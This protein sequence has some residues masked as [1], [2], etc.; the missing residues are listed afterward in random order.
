LLTQ[1]AAKNRD[2][3]GAPNWRGQASIDSLLRI[4]AAIAG[5]AFLATTAQAQFF[6]GTARVDVTP[7]PGLVMGGYGARKAPAAK[8]H[9]PLY[10]TALV[11]ESPD[12]SVAILT[13]DHRY[14]FSARAEEEI[15]RRFGIQHVLISSSHTH[16]GPVDVTT[17]IEDGL[18][19]A[20]GDAHA[21]RFPAKLAAG[22][23]SVYLGHNRRLIKADGKVEMFWRNAERKPT[24]P[25]D[26]EV[27][28][29]RIDDADGKTRALLVNYACH[30]TVL[31]PDN[32]DYSA[33]YVNGLRQ[34]L[35][36]EFPQSLALFALGA[37]GD[38]N[39]YN[40]KEPI[41]GPAFAVAQQTG[42]AL[43]TESARVARR[44]KPESPTRLQF[45]TQ[46]YTFEHRFDANKTV[47][48]A[49]AVGL[50]SLPSAKNAIAI[51]TLSGEPFVDH[52]IHFRDRSDCNTS[53]FFGQTST[54]GTPGARYLPTLQAASEGGYGAD[55]DTTVEPGAGEI[56]VDRAIVQTYK[57]LGHLKKVPNLRY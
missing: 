29:L 7:P 51:A 16:S 54:L 57:F 36:K 38:I 18:I 11:L 42:Q 6:A 43:A 47:D 48:V 1:A 56:L 23:G 41:S 30:P 22:T 13:I 49:M 8:T 9:D 24:D 21:N 15:R 55:T 31:G 20:A 14:A 45:A 35:E 5:L 33:D 17:Q 39:P 4:A 19:K 40:D 53:L 27:S 32:L 34:Q 28:V 25:V 10:V 3:K 50:I 52:Q 44:L 37:A 12:T 46:R 2:R 26:P